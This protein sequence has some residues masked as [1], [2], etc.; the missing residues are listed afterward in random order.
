MRHKSPFPPSAVEMIILTQLFF[1]FSNALLECGSLLN[2]KEGQYKFYEMWKALP[3]PHYYMRTVSPRSFSLNLNVNEDLEYGVVYG[4]E[5]SLWALRKRLPLLKRHG[6]YV[7]WCPGGGARSDWSASVL[8]SSC[9]FV[10]SLRLT[11]S[12]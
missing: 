9:L 11:W 7:L 1:N 2:L 10:P 8:P 4:R 6:V 12:S 5:A 3:R